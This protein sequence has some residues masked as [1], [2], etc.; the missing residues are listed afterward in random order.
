MFFLAAA[1][2]SSKAVDCNMPKEKRLIYLHIHSSLVSGEEK[3]LPGCPGFDGIDLGYA[4]LTM[5]G[6]NFRI[7]REYLLNKQYEADGP[8]GSISLHYYVPSFD[9]LLP[10][11]KSETRTYAL[12]TSVE[13]DVCI[14]ERCYSFLESDLAQ[15]VSR[16]NLRDDE[17]H[18]LKVKHK[19]LSSA[20]KGEG[21]LSKYM[22]SQ[23]KKYEVAIKQ[24]NNGKIIDW[25]YCEKTS[26]GCD[27]FFVFDEKLWVQ[28]SLPYSKIR[29]MVKYKSEFSKFLTNLI[30]ANNE[31]GED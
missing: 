30:D 9:P 28:L 10:S 2:I 27:S 11:A 22:I 3:P 7:P 17:E 21:V 13:D 5:A 29:S 8:T 14:G 4:N 25:I 19:M 18:I 26:N 6:L 12:I 20:I 1:P 15:Q 23:S 16:A 24:E 31:T